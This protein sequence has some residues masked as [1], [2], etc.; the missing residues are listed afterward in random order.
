MGQ[1]HSQFV[2]QHMLAPFPHTRV[3]LEQAHSKQQQVV[4]V[5]AVALPELPFIALVDIRDDLE[6]IDVLEQRVRPS[7]L[8]LIVVKGLG[9]SALPTVALSSFHAE[10]AGTEVVRGLTSSLHLRD[11]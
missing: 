11:Q 9:T 5:E 7:V 1:D 10:M 4:K 3:P 8:V 6:D 2:Y